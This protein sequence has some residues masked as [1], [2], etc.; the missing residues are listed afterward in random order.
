[1]KKILKYLF[2]VSLFFFIFVCVG[3]GIFI[4]KIL[5]DKD[6][7]IFDYSK[8]NITTTLSQMEIYDNNDNLITYNNVPT[9]TS[10][11][12]I[13]KNT[14]D[15]FLSIEDKNFYTHNGTNIKRIIKACINNLRSGSFKEG[16]STISQQLIKNTHLSSD[17]TIERKIREIILTKK[18]EQELTKDQILEAY[19]NL[20]Y[21][22]NGSYGITEASLNYFNKSPEELNLAE[23]AL[24]AGLIK[25]PS[26]YSPYQNLEKAKDRRNLVLMEMLEDG[27]ITENEYSIAMNSKIEIAEKKPEKKNNAK[28]INLYEKLAIQE[29]SKILDLNINQ[30]KDFKI[31][32][33][34]NSDVSNELQNLLEDDT[35]F[36]VN[37]YG[38]I[39]SGLSIVL[40][41]KTGGVEAING[42]S[43]YELDLLNRQPGSAIKPILVYAPAIDDG[44]VSP[45][46]QI[47][48]EKIDIDGYS[49]NNVGGFH[50]YVSVRESV[51]KSLNVPAIKIIEKVGLNNA[52]KF[53][54]NA[55]IKFDSKDNNY[56]IALGGFTEGIDLKMLTTSYLPFSNG[57]NFI[58]STFIKEIRNK[59]DVIVYK[60][61]TSQKKIMGEDTA[62]LMTDMLIDG[63]KNGTSKKLSSL[64]FQIAGKTG[65]VAVK[66]TNLNNDAISIA[67]TTDK[68]MGVWFGNYSMEKE[69]QLESSNNGGTYATALI[70]DLFSNIYKESKPPNFEMPE[71]ITNI[72]LD[73]LE[74]E[75]NLLMLAN[76]KT[77]ERYIIEEVFSKRFAPTI[78]SNNFKDYKIENFQVN[79]DKNRL[80][81]EFDCENYMDYLI[82]IYSNNEEIVLDRISEENGLLCKSYNIDDFD[83]KVVVY[84]K[85]KYNFDNKYSIS[86][87]STIIKNQDKNQFYKSISSDFSTLWTQKM[88]L[89]FVM[90]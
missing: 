40:D 39:P 11:E 1:M 51:C 22:G 13:N 57:G 45:A 72:K 28:N 50:G 75:N 67:Y 78:K 60:H 31:Y 14:I 73:R 58:D 44:I 16:A 52:K 54:E 17:K 4:V 70:R 19:L 26:K 34:K 63:V 49:P 80:K 86:N 42:R 89:K 10:I 38:N 77:P 25:A 66:D 65:T 32:T 62:Y 43:D 7:L 87:K 21:F 90:F 23:S 53:A 69:Y 74:L 2:V 35:Y 47:L 41:N 33:Y 8:L 79:Y 3:S 46:T 61:N 29:A 76:D 55:G 36:E 48:D 9:Y 85:Y 15:A 83:N 5:T 59:D 37:S 84:V 6:S 27:K 30:L 68:T 64:P 56:A 81:V 18:M 71:S 20:I 82:C 24:L 12:S 88:R